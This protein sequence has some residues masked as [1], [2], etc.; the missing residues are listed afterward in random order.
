MRYIRRGT[1]LRLID[2]SIPAWVIYG[3]AGILA[4]IAAALPLRVGEPTSILHLVAFL[5]VITAFGLIGTDLSALPRMITVID[6]AAGT[7]KVRWRDGGRHGQMCIGL[8]EVTGVRTFRKSLANGKSLWQLEFTQNNGDAV[9]ISLPKRTASE[10]ETIARNLR[11][12]LNL[13]G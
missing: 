3:A 13:G 7:I 10:L 2:R 12:D 11:S 9:P 8:A 6:R 1:T 4:A 5:C